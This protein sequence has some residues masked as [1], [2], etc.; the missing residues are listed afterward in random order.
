[1]LDQQSCR[2]TACLLSQENDFE[3]HSCQQVRCLR[4]QFY[5]WIVEKM[6]KLQT[7]IYVIANRNTHKEPGC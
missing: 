2:N 7:K 1:M 6:L 5:D 3:K 4:M